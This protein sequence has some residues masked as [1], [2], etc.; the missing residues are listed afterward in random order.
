VAIP[1][2]LITFGYGSRSQEEALALLA[3]HRVDYLIDVRSVPWSRYRP[4]FSQDRLAAFLRA[5]GIR[6]TSA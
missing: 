4:E 2:P 1:S 6:L 5:H 3:R